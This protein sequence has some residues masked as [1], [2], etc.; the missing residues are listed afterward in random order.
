MR[1]SVPMQTK[2]V[3]RSTTT[4]WPMSSSSIVGIP[5]GQSKHLSSYIARSDRRASSTPENDGLGR[6]N[7]RLRR[8]RKIR[9]LNRAMRGRARGGGKKGS[10]WREA[11][12]LVED[13]VAGVRFPKFA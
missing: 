8:L 7:F 13:P 5:V 10:A 12:F 1:E 6:K 4:T 9:S 2:L 3:R 11:G